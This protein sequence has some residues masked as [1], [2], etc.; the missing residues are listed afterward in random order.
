M[1]QIPLPDI[2]D[3]LSWL[4]WVV[5]FLALPEV[6][7]T[8]R[9]LLFGRNSRRDNGSSEAMQKISETQVLLAEKFESISQRN[10]EADK[11]I[12]SMLD[13]YLRNDYEAGIL[14]EQIHDRIFKDSRK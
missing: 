13:K 8:S 6:L 11:A 4:I 2:P 10:L 9:G 3:S 14:I 7:R 5:G 1:E 12:L